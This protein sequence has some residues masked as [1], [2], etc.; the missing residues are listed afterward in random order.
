MA[1]VR[2]DGHK[3]RVGDAAFVVGDHDAHEEYRL[4][5]HTEEGEAEG[6]CCHVCGVE[7][8]RDCRLIACDFCMREFHEDCVASGPSDGECDGGFW[9]CAECSVGAPPRRIAQTHAQAFALLPGALWL[10]RI[11]ALWEEGGEERMSARVYHRALD[12]AAGA[13]PHDPRAVLVPLS[14]P[15]AA[16]VTKPRASAPEV[17]FCVWVPRC[18]DEADA[19]SDS[20]GAG[21]AARREVLLCDGVSDMEADRLVARA[22]VVPLK[23]YKPATARDVFVCRAGYAAASQRR[24]PL[25]RIDGARGEGDS[26]AASDFEAEVRSLRALSNARTESQ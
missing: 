5:P 19:P 22:N 7:E 21:S 10:V 26:D 24:V 18:A 3:Y 15:M 4:S 9:R 8:R 16:C 12:V 17:P 13:C 11:E 20:P 2:V 25:A 1:Q 14:Q 6:G 23:R